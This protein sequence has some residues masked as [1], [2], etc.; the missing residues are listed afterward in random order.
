[1]WIPY[2]RRWFLA[3]ELA[4]LSGF[5]VEEELARSAEVP[6]DF[7]AERYNSGFIGNSARGQR[8]VRHGMRAVLPEAL[9]PAG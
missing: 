5:P 3:V 7:A 4:A 8:R 9:R 6:C 2:L 1:M